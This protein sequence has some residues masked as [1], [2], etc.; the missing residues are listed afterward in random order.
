[1]L[2][3]ILGLAFLVALGCIAFG[4]FAFY[5][6]FSSFCNWGMVLLITIGIIIIFIDTVHSLGVIVLKVFG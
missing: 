5:H 3:F 6:N 1:M 2:E 4:L